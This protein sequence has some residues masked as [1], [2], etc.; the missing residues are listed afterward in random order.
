MIK[1]S[2]KT[3]I[4]LAI[5]SDI[6]MYLARRYKSSGWNIVGSY[7]NKTKDLEEFSSDILYPCNIDIEESRA[8]FIRNIQAQKIRWNVFISCIG[9]LSPLT[10]FF[11]TDF[12][13]W[14]S[15]V[16]TNSLSQLA[17]LHALYNFRK[18][19]ST[20]HVVFFAGGAINK[21]TPDISAYTIGKIILMKMCELIL[22]ESPDLVPFIIGPGWT[23]TKIHRE[24]INSGNISQEKLNETL[25]FLKTNHGTSM[26]DIYDCIEWMR[27][28]PKEVSGGRNISAVHDPWRDARGQELAKKLKHDTSMFTLRRYDR[29]K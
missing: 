15:S 8:T 27:S 14:Q 1:N 24:A 12:D 22:C 16:S 18:K 9:V 13:L 2:D 19:G 3:V 11:A 10:P 26:E 25:A 29:K 23:K 21:A 20:N 6:G 28:Q 7:R 5:T 4:I 17:L